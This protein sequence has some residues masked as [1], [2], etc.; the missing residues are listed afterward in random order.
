[1]C[2]S[3]RQRRNQYNNVQ[4]KSCAANILP[5]YFVIFFISCW[6]FIITTILSMFYTTFGI[7]AN[8]SLLTAIGSILFNSMEIEKI[9][10]AQR[11]Q[12][13][14]YFQNYL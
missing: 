6:T 3:Q 1:M 13:L 4:I 7:I 14:K 10:R 12:K 8:L 11:N 9:N 2:I 5:I